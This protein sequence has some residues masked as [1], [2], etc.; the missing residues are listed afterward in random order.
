[1]NAKESAAAI[2]DLREWLCVQDPRKLG[3]SFSLPPLSF[4]EIIELAAEF[5]YIDRSAIPKSVF[6]ELDF[7]AANEG[8]LAPNF[9]K[10]PLLKALRR[11]KAAFERDVRSNSTETFARFLS[12][13]DSWL[14]ELSAHGSSKLVQLNESEKWWSYISGPPRVL[15]DRNEEESFRAGLQ[16]LIWHIWF[17]NSA[18]AGKPTDASARLGLAVAGPVIALNN[19]AVVATARFGGNWVGSL[20]LFWDFER[21]IEVNDFDLGKPLSF[22]KWLTTSL[23]KASDIF[24]R[25][26]NE[27]N[28]ELKIERDHELKPPENEPPSFRL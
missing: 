24:N 10:S 11:Q 27:K 5:G 14:A 20:R 3:E 6:R 1:M 28:L 26:V 25:C 4:Y 18:F 8:R 21:L 16:D 17:I 19:F 22:E 23:E 7:I 9:G 15:E 12:A 2:S 13:Y